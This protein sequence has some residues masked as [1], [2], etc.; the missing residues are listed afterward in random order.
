M[1]MKPFNFLLLSDFELGENVCL[2]GGPH[3]YVL[4][5]I[6]VLIISVN[7]LTFF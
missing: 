3:M 5:P 4:R 2:G 7:P 6:E 1:L